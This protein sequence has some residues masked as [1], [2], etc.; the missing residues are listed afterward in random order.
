MPDS[1]LDI[2]PDT[3]FGPATLPYGVF[4]TAD[5]PTTR[6][7]VAV[8]GHVLDLGAAARALD[9]PF[10]T[11][12]SGPNLDPLLAAGRPV[13]DRVRAALT[14]WITDSAHEA[15]V[16]PHLVDRAT[17][18]LHLPFT[19]ADYV[20]FYASEHHATNVGRMFRP[21]QEPLTPN[22]RHLPIGYH[23]RSGTI[24]VSG[25]D[26][27]RPTG[28]RKPPTE[29]T[30][31]F[32]PSARLDIEAE[33]GFV[34]GTPSPMGERVAVDDFADH[35]FGVFLLNDWSSRDLQAW[36]YVPLGPFL[37][38]SFAT[39]VSPWVV[40]V[41]ALESA[42]VEQPAQDP[43]PLPYL[44]GSRSWGLDLRLEVR[45]NGHLVSTPPFSEM[46]W[47]AA[48]QLA[49]MTVN[50][51]SL[52]T[53]DVYAS[54]TVSGPEVSQ[55]GCFLELTWSGKEPLRLPDGTERTFLE[56][57]DEVTI[58]ATA[59]G[60]DGARIDFGEVTGRILPAR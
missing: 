46:Y 23:G 36:E 27:V 39:S 10:A 19:V 26:V 15:A 7:G 54:G 52:R 25:T 30:P 28:Q 29:P 33:V 43:E 13:W 59:P 24:V 1:W 58:S 35:V 45:L 14:S 38:K 44:R 11:A 60:P 53:G 49:H 4:S 20:D 50:G 22:W 42:R 9:A 57:G 2:A 5:D 12:V 8:G 6:V 18:T 32:G 51:A 41:A 55:R 17:V 34:V 21:D 48:Q 40:P 31:V 47:T 3:Q 56:D 16:R 37:G